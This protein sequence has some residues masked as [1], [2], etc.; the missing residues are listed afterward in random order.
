MTSM[1][2]ITILPDRASAEAQTPVNRSTHRW[3]SP[4]L[5]Y[6]VEQRREEKSISHVWSLCPMMP[7]SDHN[8]KERSDKDRA[9]LSLRGA[10]RCGRNFFEA[11]GSRGRAWIVEDF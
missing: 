4:R 6:R 3:K 2:V 1:S 10:R 9:K 8:K 11:P 5:P 7:T